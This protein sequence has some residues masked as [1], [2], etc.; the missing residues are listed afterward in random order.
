MFT[1]THILLATIVMAILACQATASPVSVTSQDLP[2]QCDPLAPV[3]AVMDELGTTAVFPL[4]ER[5]SATFT[6]VNPDV[7]ATSSSPA[8]P[9]AELRITNLT[10]ISF[11]DLHYVT[12]A[13][14]GF[15]NFDGVINGFE[16]VRLDNVGVNQPLITEF[17]GS[18]P[19]V[20]EPGEVWVVVLDD[21]GN[22]SGL[23]PADLGSIGVPSGPAPDLSSGSIVAIPIP[24][25][26]SMALAALGLS[27]LAVLPRR[28]P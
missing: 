7:C 21:W 25:P 1:R 10:T 5:I 12:D 26:G 24:E 14:T 15:T 16:A 11:T 18:Q 2:N 27:L 9:N 23:T 19:L 28:K 22:G 6:F 17:G 3:P 8:V 4:D 13:D 20:F